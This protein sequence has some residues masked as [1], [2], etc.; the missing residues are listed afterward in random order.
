MARSR[1]TNDVEDVIIIEPD[2]MKIQIVE[3]HSLRHDSSNKKI[4]SK[5]LLHRRLIWSSGVVHEISLTFWSFFEDVT[6]N[7]TN[8][9]T[10]GTTSTIANIE[11]KQEKKDEDEEDQQQEDPNEDY[12]GVCHDGTLKPWQIYKISPL[13]GTVRI[14]FHYLN[15]LV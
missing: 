3:S 9:T 1:T 13:L 12:C 14:V 2:S 15:C 5:G 11:I 10:T 7:S 8:V 6:I 4:P